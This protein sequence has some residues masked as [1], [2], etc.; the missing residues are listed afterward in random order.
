VRGTSRSVHALVKGFQ[1]FDPDVRVAGVIF[2][3]VGS[4]R[5]R[6]MI[7][8]GRTTASFGC[9]PRTP[10]I[11]VGSRHLGLAMAHEADALRSAGAVVEAHCDLD[12]IL[13]AAA[14]AGPV[15]APTGMRTA[16]EDD[17]TV[18]IGVARD[19]AFCFYY[20]DNLDRL[21]AA[22][23]QIVVFSPMRDP[24]PDLD[25]LYLGGGY[26]E[27]H[28]AALAK[29]EA[30]TAIHRAA[31]NGMPV[32]GECGGLLYMA[33]YLETDRMYPM[34][35]VLPAEASME[36]R[37]RALGYAEGR[38]TDRGGLLPRGLIMRGHE[39][40]YSQVACAE[41]ARFAIRLDRGRGIRD[42]HDGLAE[43][44]ALGC[45]THAYFSD[46]FARALVA[47]AR[48]YRWR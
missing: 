2:N 15:S 28:A 45:Y 24:L 7:E 36:R 34:A 29:G 33:E 31:E 48:R 35:G 19:E 44:Q 9:I 22:G 12:A 38:V 3:R 17:W 20:A 46:R 32:Y 27:L 43:H 25:G 11:E 5:H 4:E 40:H 13:A 47:A 18:R 23:A 10:E 41:D 42:G 21:A 30:R 39:F 37:M 26:P 1:T 16:T 8:V 6:T 14:S